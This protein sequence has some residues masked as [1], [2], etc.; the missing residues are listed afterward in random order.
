M[1]GH[2]HPPRDSP[3]W[4]DPDFC[5]FCGA[6]LTDGGAGFVDHLEDAPEC[7]RRFEQWREQVVDD[8][9]GEWG[10]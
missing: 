1:A 2:S 6:K 5:P 7:A 10:G 8:V 4:D 3:E 9:G